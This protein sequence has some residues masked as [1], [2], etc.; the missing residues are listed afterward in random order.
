MILC[1]IAF[2]VY[3]RFMQPTFLMKSDALLQGTIMRAVIVSITG[4]AVATQKGEDKEVGFA[5]L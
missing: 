4:W 2:E 1:H 5:P 3:F